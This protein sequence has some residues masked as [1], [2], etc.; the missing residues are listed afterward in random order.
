[1]PGPPVIVLPVE[2]LPLPGTP[3]PSSA[4]PPPP[5]PAAYDFPEYRNSAGL[6][7]MDAATAYAA[8]ANG[9]GVTVGIVDTGILA[10]SAEFQGRIASLSLDATGGGRGIGDRAGHGTAVASIIGAARNGVGAMGVAYRSTLLVLRSEM[11]GSCPECSFSDST[12]AHAID[13]AVADKARVINLSM[14]SDSSSPE[15]VTAIRKA[16]KA[17]VVVVIA[18]GNEYLAQP[19]V[20]AQ[21]ASDK[22]AAGMVLVVGSLDP[23]AVTMSSFS[24]R[25]GAWANYY[26]SA[27]GRNV[28]ILGLDGKM[29][30][31]SGTSF[32]APQ[33]TGAVALLAQAFPNLTG[34]DIVKILLGSAV[35]LGNA[36]VTGKGRLSLT[37]AMK[38]IGQVSLPDAGSPITPTGQSALSAPF[39]DMTLAAG[40]L[41]GIIGLDSYRRAYW[42]NLDGRLHP[43]AIVPSLWPLLSRDQTVQAVALGPAMTSFYVT[44]PSLAAAPAG[45]RESGS[46]AYRPERPALAGALIGFRPRADL[47]VQLALGAPGAAE[48]LTAAPDRSGPRLVAAQDPLATLGL[49]ARPDQ[50]L[51][52]QFAPGPLGLAVFAE[53]GRVPALLPGGTTGRYHAWGLGAERQL[54]RLRLN[55]AL[56][57]LSETDSL[58]GAQWERAFGIRGASTLFVDGRAGWQLAP[59]WHLAGALRLGWTRALAAGGLVSAARLQTSASAV[60]L[61]GHGLLRGDDALALT[62]TRPLRIDAAQFAFDLP[63]GYSYASERASYQHRVLATAPHGREQVIEAGYRARLGM[64]V[65]D[66]SLAW[67]SQPANRADAGDETI[68]ATT[69][70]FA[71]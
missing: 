30:T 64:A 4:P 59:H 33:V 36:A 25:A 34:K 35:D 10:T 55:A 50:A 58:L 38:P 49:A 11:P 20:F 65:I 8:G 28:P 32:A 29:T 56:T 45:A 9:N 17:G 14:G 71:W 68:A 66:A 5:V 13:L 51:A 57:G 67:R 22:D 2:P 39:G 46:A 23:D 43:P 48:L 40:T 26:L 41:N 70:R 12:V 47:G 63:V 7:A 19:S 37:N 62:W 31:G 21:V 52:A 61:T 60:A 15:V 3:P 42:F 16:A 69:V 18:S 27:P 54:G 53:Q 1:M 6:T 24:N 44:T